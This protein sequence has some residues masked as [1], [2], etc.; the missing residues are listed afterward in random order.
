MSDLTQSISLLAWYRADDLKRRRAIAKAALRTA[1]KDKK[2]MTGHGMRQLE[3]DVDD[4]SYGL[5]GRDMLIVL[6]SMLLSM[7]LFPFKHMPLAL[8]AKT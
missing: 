6:L 5:A 7:C 4:V 8:Q 2:K 3:Q 1:L